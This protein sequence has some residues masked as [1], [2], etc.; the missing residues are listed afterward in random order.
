MAGV[1]TVMAKQDRVKF[2][3]DH[4]RTYLSYCAE[5][6]GKFNLQLR[7]LKFMLGGKE[8]V[9]QRNPVSQ[10]EIVVLPRT[11]P[12]SDALK[13]SLSK[14]MHNSIYCDVE[15]H[16]YGKATEERKEYAEIT[17]SP[18]ASTQASS[19]D[20]PNTIKAH[21]CILMARS[22]KFEAMLRHD[23][24]EQSS[25]VVEIHESRA[26][27]QTFRRLI[28]WLY[29]G[30]TELPE[31][32]YELI[33]LLNL[34]DEYLLPDLAKVCHDYILERIDADNVLEVLTSSEI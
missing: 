23:M 33:D 13:D 3:L 22:P 19:E 20:K 24:Q 30:R 11:N 34:S 29:T 14:I 16:V 32:I 10:C 21:K 9:P 7:H 5:F 6:C 12:A 25:S 15:L 31:D 2:E 1:E 17:D 4:V 27:T 18:G 8:I 28:E 26:S